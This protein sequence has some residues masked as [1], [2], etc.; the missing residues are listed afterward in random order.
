MHF[1]KNTKK[2]KIWV[3]EIEANI[4]LDIQDGPVKNDITGPNT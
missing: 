3:N 4:V 1:K 2:V